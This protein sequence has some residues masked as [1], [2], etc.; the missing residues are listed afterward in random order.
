MLVAKFDLKTN[1]SSVIEI[2]R[3]PQ[4]L[5]LGLDALCT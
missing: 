2:Q 1:M 5:S 4:Y 3:K